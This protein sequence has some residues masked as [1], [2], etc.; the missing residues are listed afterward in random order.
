MTDATFAIIPKPWVQSLQTFHRTA[1]AKSV[2]TDMTFY[3]T[4]VL[5]P[6]QTLWRILSRKK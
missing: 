2:D 3:A 1:M 5:R 6:Y 4:F